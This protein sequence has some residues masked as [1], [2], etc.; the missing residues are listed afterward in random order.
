LATIEGDEN[1]LDAAEELQ[2]QALDVFSASGNERE[3]SQTLGML[4]FVYLARGDYAAARDVC[5]RALEMSRAAGDERGILVAASNLGHALA[6][7]GEIDRALEL[8]REALLLA[9]EFFD[10]QGI[11]EILLDVAWL[12]VSRS[13]Y[14]TAGRLLGAIPALAE[15]AEFALVPV[16]AEWYD[17]MFDAV[18]DAIGTEALDRTTAAGRRMGLDELVSYAVAFM[19]STE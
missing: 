14:D 18:R 16:E 17:E 7:D 6:R 13:V 2:R 10:L 15:S 1:N 4:G 11:G 12:A 9:R 5:E 19:D 8:Q 3:I